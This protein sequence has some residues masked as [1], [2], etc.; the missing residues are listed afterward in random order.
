M[1][2]I[3]SQVVMVLSFSLNSSIKNFQFIWK[4]LWCSSFFL[5]LTKINEKLKGT[6]LEWEYFSLVFLD[7]L[8][9]NCMLIQI[10]N[11]IPILI[12]FKLLFEWLDQSWEHGLL[13]NFYKGVRRW[14]VVIST[15]MTSSI[16]GRARK[17]IK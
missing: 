12:L 16:F 14:H 9:F 2:P 10:F 1:S 8:Y 5:K 3:Q 17:G 15:R 7:N 6:S 13:F 11:W 4:C